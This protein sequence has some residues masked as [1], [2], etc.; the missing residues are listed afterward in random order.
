MLMICLVFYVFDGIGIIVEIIGYS[1][2]IQFFGFSF[3]IDCM[4]FVDDFEKVWEVCE[5]ICVVGECYQVWLIVV[6]FCV[7]SGLSVILVE[8]GGLML[9]VFVFFIELLECELVVSCYFWVGQVYGMVDFEIYYWCIN[10]MN[11]VLI[12]DDGIVINYDDVDVILVV[13]LWVG[14]IFICIYLV[15]Y[16]GVCVVNY[17]LID[18][19]LEQDWLLLWLCFYCKKLFGLMIDLDCL[20]QICQECCLNLC[21]VNLEICCCEVVVVEIMFCMECILIL[22]IIYIFIE[23]IL[24]KVLVML[25]LQWEM[26]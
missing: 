20:Q 7:D 5:W 8:S 25:G 23:E 11:F 3:I 13:V 17:L 26:Y 10:V 9:D 4:F 2:L 12:Y 15:L 24:S 19:D 6:S 18:E 14:K 16:Y 21:Y 1:L 22:S